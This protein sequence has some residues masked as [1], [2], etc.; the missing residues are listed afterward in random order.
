[1]IRNNHTDNAIEPP[2]IINFYNLVLLITNTLIHS[3][4]LPLPSRKQEANG[5]MTYGSMTLD[6][7]THLRSND[8]LQQKAQWQGILLLA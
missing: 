7:M 2:F 8:Y 4:F 1:M 5:A 6:R 3:Q